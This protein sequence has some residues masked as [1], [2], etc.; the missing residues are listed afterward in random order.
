MTQTDDW[1]QGPRD[2]K[3]LIAGVLALLAALVVALAMSGCSSGGRTP[4]LTSIL[5]PVW[6]TEIEATNVTVDAE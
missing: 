4:R 2:D 5:D 3:P 1:T 6:H